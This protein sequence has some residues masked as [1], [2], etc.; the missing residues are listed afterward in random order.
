MPTVNRN[1][2]ITAAA[3]RT[4]AHTFT[5]ASIGASTE[6]GPHAIGST[7]AKTVWIANQTARFKTTPTTAAVMA[8]SAPASAWL[9]RRISMKGAPRKIQRKHGIREQT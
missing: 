3:D 7:S 4:T 2:A 5:L 8:D 6:S 1:I 9:P